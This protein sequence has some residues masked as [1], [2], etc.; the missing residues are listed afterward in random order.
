[1]T[2]R[3]SKRLSGGWWPSVAVA[4]FTILVA[5]LTSRVWLSSAPRYAGKTAAQWYREFHMAASSNSAA[6]VA[7]ASGTAQVFSIEE[8][9]AELAATGLR[10]LGTNA[11]VYLG[12]EY[13]RED[14]TVAVSYRQFY[15][16]LPGMV[17]RILPEPAVPRHVCRMYL[18]QALGV[19]GS[20]ASAAAPYLVE[21]LRRC[22]DFSFRMTL[23]TLRKTGFERHE[24]DRLLADWAREGRHTNILQVIAELEVRTPVAAGCLSQVLAN[25]DIP[26]RL[27]CIYELEKF[28]ALAVSALPPLTAALKQPRVELRYAA[29][30][31]LESIGGAAG[32]AVPALIHATNDP[33]LM[34]RRASARALEVIQRHPRD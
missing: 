8:V 5:G 20:K 27:T 14:G 7:G 12:E 2:M 33:S 3:F 18:S 34:V 11:A 21:S 22:D 6:L 15:S 25:A 29:A 16:V 1:M 4:F 28:G 32:R 10:E 13:A 23:S 24:L 9:P 26:V 17:Q 19:T 30:R 31:T